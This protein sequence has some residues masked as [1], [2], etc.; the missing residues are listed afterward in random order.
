MSEGRIVVGFDIDGVI[1]D[2]FSGLIGWAEGR[3][4]RIGCQSHEVDTYS[5]AQAFPDLDEQ[6]IME[7]IRLFSVEPEFGLL[8][9]YPGAVEAITGLVQDF[10][11]MELVAITSAGRSEIT[12]TLRLQNLAHMPFSEVHVIPLGASKRSYFDNL[13]KGSLYVDDLDHHARSAED[14]GL[15]SVLYRQPYNAD[16]DYHNAVEGWEELEACI[17]RHLGA[18]PA[19]AA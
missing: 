6:D 7:M 1:L 19:M 4:V 16:I 3:G 13:P 17:R 2:Y 11:E 18:C 12:K 15:T 10:P 9:P 5:M 8:E 14:A